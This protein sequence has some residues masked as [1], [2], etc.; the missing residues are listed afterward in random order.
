MVQRFL[1]HQVRNWLKYVNCRDRKAFVANLKALYQAPNRE[2]AE[3]NLLA[4]TER[5]GG[6]YGAAMRS[7]E[8]NW[9][10]LAVMFQFPGEIRRLIYTTNP[11][12]GY[13]R[14]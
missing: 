1:V 2:A 7:W 6:K 12:E 9:E 5:W 4:V 10:E 8:T 13:N 3:E 14:Q 11:I